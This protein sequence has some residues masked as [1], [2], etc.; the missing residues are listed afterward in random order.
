MSAN[1]RQKLGKSLLQGKSQLLASRAHP[2]QA[3]VVNYTQQ[4]K[5]TVSLNFQLDNDLTNK[6]LH[7]L[8]L[9]ATTNEARDKLGQLSTLLEYFNKQSSNHGLQVI[10]L[11]E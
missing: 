10:I 1:L 2:G 7:R 9:T 5:I 4:R 3:A 8:R 11:I 6:W